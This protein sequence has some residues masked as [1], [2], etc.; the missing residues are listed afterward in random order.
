M[1]DKASH[2][3][4]DQLLRT[5]LWSE[6]GPLADDTPGCGFSFRWGPRLE[7]SGHS[8]SD[9]VCATTTDFRLEY[10]R[11]AVN[12]HTHTRL[13]ELVKQTDAMLVD[14]EEC[15]GGE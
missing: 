13:P 2:W 6:G 12:V 14:L 8:H 7:G 10:Y 9:G 11:A 5:G 3:A 4:T 1:L 15:K